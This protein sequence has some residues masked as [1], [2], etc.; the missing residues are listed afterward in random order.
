MAGSLTRVRLLILPLKGYLFPNRIEP[1]FSDKLTTPRECPSPMRTA[2][3]EHDQV[4]HGLDH[5]VP[6]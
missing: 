2:I 6:L 1:K 4:M 3:M 5:L